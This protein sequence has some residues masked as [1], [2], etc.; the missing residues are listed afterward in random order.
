MMPVYRIRDGYAK[1]TLNEAIFEA[2][3]KLLFEQKSMLIFPEAQHHEEHYL[4]PLS[5]GVVRIALQ[6]QQESENP[7]Y[8][9]PVGINYFRHFHPRHKLTL[10]YGKPIDVRAYMDAYRDN[11]AKCLNKLREDLSAGI[12]SLLIIPESENYLERKEIFKRRNELLDFKTIRS[13]AEQLPIEK[14]SHHN[15]LRL[16]AEPLM[17]F[18]VPFH[19]FNFY[20]MNYKVK[21]VEFIGSLKFAF[22]LLLFPIWILVSFVVVTILFSLKISLLLVLIQITSLLLRQQLLRYTH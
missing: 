12:K 10:N 11:Q 15:W 8:I 4:H 13:Q 20:V 9:I 22:G 1:L 3:K 7:I 14:E 18:N 17:I 16:L 19:L 6:T 21:E 2:S 5:K